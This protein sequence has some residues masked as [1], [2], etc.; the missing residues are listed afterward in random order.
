[1][2]SGTS[3]RSNGRR[4]KFFFYFFLLDSFKREKESK[5][6]RKETEL[7]NLFPDSVGWYNTSSFLQ[8]Q[9]PSQQQHQHL[10]ATTTLVA[11][12]TLVKPTIT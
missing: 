8:R 9:L 7:L 1:M 11:P 3:V 5:K 10:P 6:E 4:P 2:A 12:T